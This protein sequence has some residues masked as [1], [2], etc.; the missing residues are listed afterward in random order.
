MIWVLIGLCTFPLVMPW[1]R[2]LLLSALVTWLGLW[3][4]MLYSP[5]FAPIL[6]G[7]WFAGFEVLFPILILVFM[8][9]LLL[10]LIVRAV[11]QWRRKPKRPVQSRL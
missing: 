8:V 6:D 10:R 11:A 2:T 4:T 7:T 9:S 1:G 5:K 3:F